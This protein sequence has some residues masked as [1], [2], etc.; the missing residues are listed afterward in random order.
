MLVEAVE[1]VGETGH[2]HFFDIEWE[3]EMELPEMVTLYTCFDNSAL[4]DEND[5]I[6]F[7]D[8]KRSIKSAGLSAELKEKLMVS[9][10]KEYEYEKA[11]S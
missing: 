7:Y 8:A 10:K 4:I 6:E 11:N 3:P 5:Y 1:V 2:S 9:L